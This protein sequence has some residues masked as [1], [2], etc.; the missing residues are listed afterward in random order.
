M[1]LGGPMRLWLVVSAL[2]SVGWLVFA[3]WGVLVERAF[4]ATDYFI[5]TFVVLAPWLITGAAAVARWVIAGFRQ[6]DAS[7]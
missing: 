6:S 5:T 7:N 3:A 2:W 4:N 1:K